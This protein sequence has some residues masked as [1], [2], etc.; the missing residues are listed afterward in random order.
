MPPQPPRRGSL[1]IVP[2]SIRPQLV[3]TGIEVYF[4]KDFYFN[5]I[6]KI[7]VFLD[8]LLGNKKYENIYVIRC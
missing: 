3:R 8:S 5:K 1:F 7:F 4:L 6:R 2:Q